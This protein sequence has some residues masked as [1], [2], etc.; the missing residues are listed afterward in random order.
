MKRKSEQ[1]IMVA[2]R[3]EDIFTMDLDVIT[4]EKEAYLEAFK[5]K[6]YPKVLTFYIKS[7][8]ITDVNH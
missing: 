7:V 3:P 6:E 1:E 8:K 5:P 4:E 2:S